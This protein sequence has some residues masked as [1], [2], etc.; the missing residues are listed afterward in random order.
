M[1]YCLCFPPRLCKEFA[2][3]LNKSPCKSEITSMVGF[4]RSTCQEKSGD[5][6]TGTSPVA[7]WLLGCV[8][9]FTN[10]H[11]HTLNLSLG[12]TCLMSTLQSPNKKMN[13]VMRAVRLQCQTGKN[14][15]MLT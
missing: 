7:G 6:V 9:T 10:T 15:E 2:D 14:A 3:A 1:N 4:P 8:G 12:P 13:F 5:A 11:I